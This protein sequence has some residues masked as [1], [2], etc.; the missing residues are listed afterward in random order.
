MP[1]VD[2]IENPLLAEIRSRGLK[3]NAGA[4]LD[5]VVQSGQI[6]TAQIA[7]LIPHSLESDRERLGQTLLWL[8]R[9]FVERQI[10][11]LAD[12]DLANR[13]LQAPSIVPILS[14]P[15]IIKALDHD[16]TRINQLVEE[17]LQLVPW[18]VKCYFYW[19]SMDFEDLVQEG[20]L[21]L[22]KAAEKYNPTIGRFSTHAFWWISQA[23]RRA[24]KN[25]AR[26]IR[27]PEPA[28]R[29]AY[30]LKNVIANLSNRL[31]RPATIEEIITETGLKRRTIFRLLAAQQQNTVSFED[32]RYSPSFTRGDDSLTIGET[33][34]DNRITNNPELRAIAK[35]E[36]TVIREQIDRLLRSSVG[37]GRNSQRNLEICQARL[38]LNGDRLTYDLVSKRFGISR[39]RVEQIVRATI[40]RIQQRHPAIARENLLSELDRLE[41]LVLLD[42][43]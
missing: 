17:N 25:Q 16:R 8:K 14:G 39:Q 37:T 12:K 5:L 3:P 41:I 22:I 11:L 19:S 38:G 34:A 18:I 15:H 30:Q 4:T 21:G 24:I 33:V 32:D 1:K 42:Q 2:I 28:Q 27:Q 40:T 23:I 9:F 6:T 31:E 35:H 29:A 10:V 26:T 20:N 36:L 7:Q 43:D 13:V